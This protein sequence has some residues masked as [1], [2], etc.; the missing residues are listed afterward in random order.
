MAAPASIDYSVI[1]GNVYL[2]H[3]R[4]LPPNGDKPAMFSFRVAV[5]S[6]VRDPNT[7]EWTNGPSTTH[8]VT[9]FGHLAENCHASFH[10]RDSVFVVGRNR[11]RSYEQNGEKKYSTDL[12]ADNA[13]VSCYWA[14][15]EQ[16]NENR[17]TGNN[18]NAP[19]DGSN[20]GGGNGNAA[21]ADNTFADP[22]PSGSEDSFDPFANPDDGGDD[23]LSSIFN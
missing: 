3:S 20:Q 18:G 4:Y 23:D 21:P 12:I 16:K 19:H 17:G 1:V 7:N 6:R 9:A 11:T 13:G 8:F 10:D 5:P 22:A 2:Q 14:P 15:C